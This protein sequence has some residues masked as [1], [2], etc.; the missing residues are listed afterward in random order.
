M[1]SLSQI[2]SEMIDDIIGLRSDIKIVE[3]D[4]QHDVVIASPANQ[5][6]RYEVLLEFEDRTRNF[7]GFRA[8]IGDDAFKQTVADVLGV[9]E[10]GSAYTIDDVDD[11]ISTR[12]DAYV[13]DFDITRSAGS[14]ATGIIRVFLSNNG[15]VG[16]D[17]TTQFTSNSGFSY[18]AVGTVSPIT[19]NFDT[20][21]G[22]YYVDI[23][24][25]AAATGEDGNAVAGAIR[26]MSPTPSNFSYCLNQANVN[27]GGGEESDLD[28]INRAETV[29]ADR[30][31]GSLGG[32]ETV[33][34]AED[35]VDD[36]LA[37]DED[38]DDNEIYIGSVVD[39][40]TQF[41]GEDVELVE[42]IFYWPGSGRMQVESF[43]FVPAKQ[44][45]LG[46]ITPI[47]FV[48]LDSGT[49]YQ[50]VA[51]EDESVL[52]SVI[53][54]TGTFSESAKANDV[55]RIKTGIP[56]EQYLTGT[57]DG[58]NGSANTLG[59]SETDFI[60]LGI[61]IGMT[62]ANITDGSSTT[63]TVVNQHSIVGVLAGGVDNTW[64]TGDAYR[65]PGAGT[66]PYARKIKVIYA[67]DKSPYKLQAIFDDVN[68]RMTGPAP[69][70]RKAVE[71]P[72]RVIAEL[73]VS[74][75]YVASEVQ[76]VVTD[77]INVFFNGGTT[78][79]GKQF[80][81]KEIGEDIAH[82]DIAKVI[83]QTEGVATY[84]TDTFYVVNT[85]NADTND[86][87][88]LKPNEYATLFDVVYEYNAASLSNFTGT[89]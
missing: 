53:K 46:T 32:F 55:I 36:A 41:V 18:N 84:D 22:L 38:D 20:T 5:F 52:V 56:I 4:T 62:V 87:T 70:V 75:G 14:S 34:M 30:E 67:Y 65:I 16:W 69:L 39:I 48:Y 82:S 72:L 61:K 26:A 2:K 51:T 44:P 3:G 74:F 83:L 47:A 40:F 78:S 1:R 57:H 15:S 12:L 54:D 58:T 71:V 33:A 11:L 19:P 59:D 13:A 81:R 27:G 8:V 50:L 25:E 9:K 23:P 43:D 68:S 37:M 77:N 17:T 79:Y 42:E 10:D 73:T 76:D 89:A 86:P 35:Y 88:D 49:E 45:L 21:T 64:E 28:L 24:I 80:A 31:N 63:I 60:A 66:I 85:L 6:Y 29:W 7:D